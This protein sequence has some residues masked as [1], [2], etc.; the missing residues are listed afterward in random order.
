MITKK[1]KI[2]IPLHPK[3]GRFGDE[4]ELR[5]ALRSINKYFKGPNEVFIISERLPNWLHGVKHIKGKYGLK[6]AV[7]V[8]AEK[9]PKGFFWF[10]DDSCILRKVNHEEMKITPSLNYFDQGEKGWCHL[11]YEIRN[12]LIK[13]GI[14]NP[15]NYSTPHGPY[16]YTKEMIDESFLHLGQMKGREPFET[17][18]LNKKKWQHKD[19]CVMLADNLFNERYQHISAQQKE[20][21][22]LNHNDFSFNK[23]LM[24]YLNNRFEVATRF[25]KIMDEKCTGIKK[26]TN[27]EQNIIKEKLE[28]DKTKIETAVEIGVGFN[29]DLENLKIKNKIL[30]EPNIECFAMAEKNYEDAKVFNFAIAPNNKSGYCLVDKKNKSYIRKKETYTKCGCELEENKD[31]FE[32]VNCVGLRSCVSENVDLVIINAKNYERLILESLIKKPSLIQIK[33]DVFLQKDIKEWL[34]KNNY[35]KTKENKKRILF[36]LKAHE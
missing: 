5:Y 4:T 1:S 7:K 12:Q 6:E 26:Q 16:W 18:I 17:W 11:L 3:G 27:T 8:A 28:Q 31:D 32:Y 25:E 34:Y 9:F 33:K 15:I 19:Q 22:Y 24:R 29:S 20:I 23:K 21:Y 36:E 35:K 10:Y 30:I 2:V 13:E 14:E